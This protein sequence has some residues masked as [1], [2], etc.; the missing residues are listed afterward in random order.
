MYTVHMYLLKNPLPL[1]NQ[2]R[3]SLLQSSNLFR[4]S[5]FSSLHIR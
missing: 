4:S 1:P 5:P 3:N 2:Y